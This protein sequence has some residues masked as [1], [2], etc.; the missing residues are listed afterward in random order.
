MR[1]G[2]LL[3]LLCLV[4]SHCT[5][6]PPS[7]D[8]SREITLE[9]D[10]R[11][12]S[13]RLHLPTAKDKDKGMPLPVVLIF[14][15][16]GD[17]GADMERATQFSE[18][19]DTQH[20]LAV[21]PNGWRHR[22]KDGRDPSSKDPDDLAFVD[23][24]LRD[25]SRQYP[26]DQRR[27]YATGFSA[28]GI[29]VHFLALHRANQLAAIASISGG[30]AEPVAQDFHPAS[31]VSVFMI[32]GTRDPLVP[33]QG[34]PVDYGLTGR[35]V[36]IAE[37]IR[38]WRREDDCSLPPLTGALPDKDPQAHCRVEW[39][40]WLSQRKH[41]EVLLYTIQGGGHAIPSGPQ[42]LPAF[43]VGPVCRDFDAAP[44]I[45]DFLNQHAKDKSRSGRN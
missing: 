7:G 25:L 12:R 39:Q 33:Y 19:A 21:Y 2:G 40:R 41:D 15:G 26:V 22:W 42:F 36:S 13:Y 23:A 30:I 27:I 11:S 16:S 9:V 43:L 8:T 6:L 44:V 31:P 17:S 3:A 5:S 35:V 4:L 18:L 34:G 10:G 38:L 1:R 24:L 45:W 29:F 37:A 14:H 32:H 28:G 20:F